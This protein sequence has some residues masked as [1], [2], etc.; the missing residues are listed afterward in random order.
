[1]HKLSNTPVVGTA[2]GTTAV[3]RVRYELVR[4]RTRYRYRVQPGV[5]GR[6]RVHV[7]CTTGVLLN[8]CVL[9]IF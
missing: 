7:E 5:H 4:G 2:L 6:T 9:L 8:L 1:M 3:V